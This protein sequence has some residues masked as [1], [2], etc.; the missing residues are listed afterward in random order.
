[1]QAIHPPVEMTG[2]KELLK[3]SD[4]ANQTIGNNHVFK[5]TAVIYFLSFIPATHPPDRKSEVQD[6]KNIGEIESGGRGRS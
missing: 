2:E 6:A 1:M 5:T 4:Q 3:S